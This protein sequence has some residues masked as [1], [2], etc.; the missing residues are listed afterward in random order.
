[1]IKI[2][3]IHADFPGT[4]IAC[5]G[6]SL[7][8]GTTLF[9]RRKDCYPARLNKLL[10]DNFDIL[11]L[12]M[13]GHTVS[14]FTSKYW[15]QKYAFKFLEA[16]LPDYIL[17]MLGTN[18]ARTRNWSDETIFRQEYG[19]LLDML[20]ALPSSPKILALTSPSAFED[21]PL[22]EE[23]FSLEVLDK[24]VR[25]QRSVLMERGTDYIDIHALTKDKE[26]LYAMDKLHFNTKGAKFVAYASYLKLKD[27]LI[28]DS[29]F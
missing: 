16:Y 12:G 29:K 24:I 14:S 10:G 3:D 1:M 19:K 5:V 20:Q 7:T 4:K 11:N 28:A 6:D 23:D 21:T 27:M 17:L 25:I 15:G 9:N 22:H 2:T 8:Y 18:D 26:H 13:V